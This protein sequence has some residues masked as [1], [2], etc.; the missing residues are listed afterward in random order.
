MSKKEISV[1]PQPDEILA[2][3]YDPKIAR[4]LWVFMRPY[5]WQYLQGIFYAFLQAGAV[6]S[7]PYLI[8]RAL[9]EGIAVGN[10]TALRTNVLLY[11]GVTALQWIMI[12]LRI[13]LMAKVG[14]SIIYNMRARLFAHLQDLSLSFFSRYS[15]GR[16]ITRVINDVSVLRQ[17]VTWAIV[18]SARDIFVLVGIV[19]AMTSLNLHLSLITFTVFP[20]MAAITVIFRS[21]ARETYRLVRAS[22]SW[23]NSVLAENVNAVRVVQA[24]SRQPVNYRFFQEVVNS[25][26]LELNLKSARLSSAYFPAI[27][28][29]GSVATGLVVWFGGQA[30]LEEQVTPGLLVAFVLYISRFFDPIRQLSQ[31]YDQMQ[32]TMAG[33]E[34]IFALL[35]TTPEVQ[36]IPEAIQL[37]KIMGTV[38]FR[39]VDFRYSDDNTPVLDAIDLSVSPGQTVALVGKT[40]AGKTTMIKLLSRFHDPTEGQV[41]VDGY[42]LQ[43]VTQ[44]SLRQQMGIVLQEPFLFNGTVAENIRFGCLDCSDE[45]VELAARAVGAHEFISGLQKGYETS[46]EEGGVVLSVGQRQLISFARALL[47]SP[48]ILILDEATSSVDTQTEMVIQSALLRLLAGR[49][50]FVIAHRLSTIVNADQIVVLDGGRIVEQGTHQQLLALDRYYARLYRMGFEE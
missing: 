23:V 21:R 30:V 16:V 7:G 26:N 44:N 34:R 6:A 42:D 27:N 15:V 2:K 10:V 35:D 31:R 48:R 41:L 8:G 12:Y 22:V 50:A 46:V 19:I 24:F 39:D 47:A 1:P 36:D 17:F 33:G 29:L 20:F 37:P 14:Q 3:R 11:I 43:T 25:H 4:R 45:E 32:S 38:E 40:G 49:T 13:N 9:D 5:R 28:F 18:A